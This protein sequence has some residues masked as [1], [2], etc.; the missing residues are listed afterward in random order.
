MEAYRGMGAPTSTPAVQGERDKGILGSAR[1]SGSKDEGQKGG[2]VTKHIYLDSQFFFVLFCFIF[3][4]ETQSASG[5][6]AERE[7]PT[8]SKAG[9]RL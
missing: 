8:E 4:R 9:S 3:E 2:T 7:G 1:R 5:E 6:G